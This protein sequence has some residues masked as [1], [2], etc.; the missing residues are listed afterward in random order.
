MLSISINRA[1]IGFATSLMFFSL[2]VFSEDLIDVFKLAEQNDPVYQQA[3][4]EYR[5]ALEAKPQAR[6]QLLP[7]VSLSA[8]SIRNEQDISSSSAFGSSG[9]VTFNSHG[10]ALNISQPLFRYDRFIALQQADSEIQQAEAELSVAQLDLIIRIAER[11]FAVLARLDDLEFSK[12]EVKS[13]RRQLDQAN[14]RFEVGLS[15]ITDVTEAQAGFDLATAREISARNAIDNAQERLREITGKYID[16][17]AP[18]GDDVPLVRPNPETIESWTETAL[19]QNLSITAAQFFT[20][21][22]RKEIQVQKSGHLPTL[23]LVA[24]QRYDSTG[25][26]FG[27]IRQHTSAIGLEFNI[28]LYEGG[29]VNSRVREAFENYN[30]SIQQLEQ[31]TRAAQRLTREAYLG[32]ISGISEI[33]ALNQAVISSETA[34]EATE[35]GFDVGTRTAVDVVA[36]QRALSDARRN[37]AVARYEYLLNSLRLKQAA[38]ILSPADLE[39]INAWLN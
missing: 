36:T 22:A 29:L 16:I 26:R 1:R 17:H 2:Q 25:G 32:V 4:A 9:D 23:D 3:I 35:A 27:G 11:Y 28:S 20:E 14:Q 24:S 39:Q 6:S 19:K 37:Y 21:T 33:K 12:A 18:L 30:S 15:A 13:L 10:Y 8:D 38:G 31:A 34:L 7:F 5:A